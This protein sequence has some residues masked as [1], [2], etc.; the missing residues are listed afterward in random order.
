MAVYVKKII[1]LAVAALI[2]ASCASVIPKELMEKGIRS[3]SFND[4]LAKPQ[5][6]QG[7]L[8]VLGGIVVATTVTDEGS[9]VEALYVPVDSYGYLRD[10]K[11]QTTR[12]LAA[13]PKGKGVLDPVIFRR[14][15]QIT[16]AGTFNGLKSG[17]IDQMDYLFPEFTIIEIHLWEELPQVVYVPRYAPYGWG[18]Y[19][20]PYWDPFWGPPWPYRYYHHYY[21]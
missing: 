2:T 9:L 1:V 8:F 5:A 20:S 18:P 16:I 17:K 3:F 12:F 14:N 19:G 15:R 6:Y 13:Y 21:R 7:Q 4:V 10:I 11:G